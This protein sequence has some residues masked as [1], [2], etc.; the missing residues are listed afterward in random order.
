[1]IKL[2]LTFEEV[3]GIIGALGEL[4]VKTGAFALVAKIQE[5]V[6]PPLPKEDVTEKPKAE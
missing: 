1:M 4:P 3:N 6:L 5:Q 2:E